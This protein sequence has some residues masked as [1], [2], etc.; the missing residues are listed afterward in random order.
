MVL[1]M[2]S[3]FAKDRIIRT[4]VVFFLLAL[5]FIAGAYQGYDRGYNE[6]QERANGWWI[7]KKSR[8]YES[9]KIRRKRITLK[10][11]QI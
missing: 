7:D 4:L 3:F 2:R 9:N 6:G 1:S 10:H 5:F 11:N 8:Y